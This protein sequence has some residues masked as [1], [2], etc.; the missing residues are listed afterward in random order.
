M[1]KIIVFITVL[2]TALLMSSCQ[3]KEETRISYEVGTSSMN[4][5][6]LEDLYNWTI[7]QGAYTNEISKL[8]FKK[9]SNSYF[10]ATGFADECDELV[11]SACKVAEASVSDKTL[12]GYA[13]IEVKATYWN[14]AGTEVIY[15]HSFGNK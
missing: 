3:T 5:T 2:F 1:K 9:E 13:T 10:T 6:S 4:L 15:S 8:G 12:E 14:N 11:L 7:I